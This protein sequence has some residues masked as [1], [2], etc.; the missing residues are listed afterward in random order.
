MGS[1][2]I[3]VAQ[4]IEVS[5]RLPLDRAI[6]RYRLLPTVHKSGQGSV[7]LSRGIGTTE[8]EFV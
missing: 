3:G 4:I 1:I 7:F 8:V 5:V 6:V 2:T